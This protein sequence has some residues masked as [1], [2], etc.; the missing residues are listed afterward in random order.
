[1][2][3]T[4]A[5]L[6]ALAMSTLGGPTQ[7]WNCSVFVA[8]PKVT[9]AGEATISIASVFAK[10]IVSVHEPEGMP[11]ARN[12][13]TQKLLTTFVTVYQSLKLSLE[14]CKFVNTNP[15]YIP[16]R[17]L[18]I[19]LQSFLKWYLHWQFLQEHL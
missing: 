14:G 19:I 9:Y 6:T 11:F 15:D 8:L 16:F 4:V 18:T 1:M 13:Y 2:F 3:T 7:I 12:S 5:F 10:N 17:L